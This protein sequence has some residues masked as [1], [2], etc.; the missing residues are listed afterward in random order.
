VTREENR[1][2]FSPLRNRGWSLSSRQLDAPLASSLPGRP[3]LTGIGRRQMSCDSLLGLPSR[4]ELT[5]VTSVRSYAGGQ[6]GSEDRSARRRHR[7]SRVSI[8]TFLGSAPESRLEARRSEIEIERGSI[9]RD[10][11]AR[12]GIPARSSFWLLHNARGNLRGLRNRIYLRLRNDM[13]RTLGTCAATSFLER[14]GAFAAR[15]K[16]G[17]G[18]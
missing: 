4:A 5:R 6:I 7:R 1:L 2:P 12:L 9:N 3:G 14:D 10:I 11:A 15:S 16:R 18:R 13:R 8:E 17:R